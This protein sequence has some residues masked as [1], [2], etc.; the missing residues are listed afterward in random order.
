MKIKDAVDLTDVIRSFRPGT[1]VKVTLLR[2][3][4]K[5]VLEVD[6]ISSDGGS[7]GTSPKKKESEKP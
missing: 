5:K 6:L 2:D 1:K 4:K 3:G 7:S